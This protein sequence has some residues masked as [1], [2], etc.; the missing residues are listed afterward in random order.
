VEEQQ[1]AVLRREPPPNPDAVPSLLPIPL[2]NASSATTPLSNL[3]SR[4]EIATTNRYG[5]WDESLWTHEQLEFES[6]LDMVPTEQGKVRLLDRNGYQDDL[7]LWACLLAYRKRIHGSPGVLTFWNAVQRRNLHLPTKGFLAEKFWPE[8][9]ALGFQDN[10]LLD[11]VCGY[12]DRMLQQHRERWSRLY[13]HVIQHLL[14]NGQGE[15]AVQWHEQ[16]FMY[17][18]PGPKAFAEM[19]RQVTFNDGDMEALR[20]IYTRNN[21]RNAYSKI[22][23]LLCQREDFRGALNWHSFFLRMGDLPSSSKVVEPLVHFLA[24]HDRPNALKVT[25]GLVDSGVSFASR[26]SKELNDNTKISREI[27]NLI[28]GKTF[29][30][31]VKKYNDSLG[32]RWFATRWVSLDVAINA[33]HAL[34][35]QEIGPLS[36]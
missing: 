30:V 35:V 6:N 15:K 36:L 1:S 23:P 26:I 27:M 14:I 4:S 21:H 17:H 34:G 7:K 33:V 2:T 13:V 31:A 22:V 11:Q 19:C 18:P 9:L 10:A 29:N 8:F 20:T 24:I 5:Q 28:H 12:A 3:S 32:A 25:K 16:L